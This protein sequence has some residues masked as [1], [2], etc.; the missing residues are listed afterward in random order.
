MKNGSFPLE[1]YKGMGI[2]GLRAD[3]FG[4]Y[5]HPRPV[6]PL[7]GRGPSFFILKERR[8]I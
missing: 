1:R 2:L 4:I 3:L 8:A 5:L 7:T 6:I